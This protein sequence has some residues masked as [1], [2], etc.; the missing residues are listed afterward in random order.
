M[1]R[2]RKSTLSFDAI[3]LEGSLLSS[4]KFAA[5][6]ERKAEEQTDAD[7][8]IPKG[9]TLRDETAR[10]FRIG[11][12]LFR[13]LHA[14]STPSRHKTVEF[15]EQLLKEVFR[16][17]DIQPI[18]APKLRDE[19]QFPLTME[20]LG[21][22]VPVI[23]VPPADDLDQASVLLSQ[24]RRRSAASALQDWLNVDDNAL[25]GLC[26]NGESL[27]LQRDNESLT[28]PVY[29]EANLHQIF[30]AEDYA[31]SHSTP[32]VLDTLGRYLR[33]ARWSA[34]VNPAARK[35]SPRAIG[36][37]T[38]SKTLSLHSAPDFSRTLP[39]R[40]SVHAC[41]REPGP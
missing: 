40:N 11:Q 20:A 33:I 21:G 29:L 23:V 34:G 12:A 14:A 15:T 6:A 5:I 41:A 18:H 13:E 16:F 9:L 3:T 4:A 25:W 30:E 22:R 39:T 35:A 28:R 36:S 1:A 24:D 32:A 10:Y 27:R 31:G 17:T 2:V 26:T 37:A 7:Y 38:V 19:R 8:N